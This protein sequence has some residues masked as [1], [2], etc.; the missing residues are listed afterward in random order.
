MQS[1]HTSATQ[2]LPTHDSSLPDGAGSQGISP[3]LTPITSPYPPPS[4]QDAT[5][6]TVPLPPPPPYTSPLHGGIHQGLFMPY[7][8]QELPHYSE[9]G[10][11]ISQRGDIQ[12]GFLRQSGGQYVPIQIPGYISTSTEENPTV[13]NIGPPSLS[14]RVR[15]H[16]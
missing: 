15:Y 4:L 5:T 7:V 12:L 6:T 8:T 13:R 14:H 10:G 3:S 11:P 9:F 16:S 1:A 2:T